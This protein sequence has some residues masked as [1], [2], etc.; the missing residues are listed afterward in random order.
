MSRIDALV[1]R[2]CPEGVPVKTLG[3]VG[4]FHR[5]NG[6]QKSNLVS[7]GFP[8][9][10]Y[11][12]IHTHYGISAS[13]TL[14]F[15]D[16]DFARRLR[17]AEP[18]DLVIA[19]TSE[20]DEAVGKA[21]AWL[22]DTAV[23]ISGD[24][25]VYRHSLDPKYMA[26]FFESR[27]LQDQKARHITGTKVRRLSGQSLAKFSVP[28]PPIEVQREIVRVLDRL[29]SLTGDLAS[30]LEAEQAARLSQYLYYRN[31]L[32]TRS[33]APV[34][35]DA[36]ENIAINHD[37]KRRP[38]TRSARVQG[39]F[40]YYGASGV[41]DYVSDYIF[42][43]DYLLVSEDGANLLA[44]SSPIAF[45]ISGKTWVNN[46]AHILEFRTYAQRRFAEIYLNS[47]DLSPY[48]SRGPQP[49]LNKANLDRIPIPVP[50]PAEQ[51]QIV[52]LLDKFEELSASLAIA[53]G[54]ERA[55]RH[56]HYVRYRDRLLAF[57]EAAA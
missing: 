30:S 17:K 1:K 20:D 53:L 55:A 2:L 41:V 13:E 42:D 4:A 31:L 51:E 50:S 45:S 37:S 44:R 48:V 9:I 16:P 26:Y 3:D 27:P 34:Q 47:I 40:P 19:T 38:V 52:S 28:V 15:V 35:W 49:K 10:H 6:M 29:S 23:A 5:G 54:D 21:V 11:G 57:E 32:L 36:L 56:Q 14:S 43:G 33:E 18:G 39:K 46:H 24:A 25:Y 7:T 12:Q 8:A 22:G